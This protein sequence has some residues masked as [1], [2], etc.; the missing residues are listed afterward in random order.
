M[1]TWAAWVHSGLGRMPDSQEATKA[2]RVSGVERKVGSMGAG[3]SV[4]DFCRCG[5]EPIRGFLHSAAL[6]SK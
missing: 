1:A 3:L 4:A 5:G 6:G 2:A